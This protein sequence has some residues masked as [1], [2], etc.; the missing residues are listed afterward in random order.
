[1]PQPNL[2]MGCNPNPFAFNAFQGSMN[3]LPDQLD[4]NAAGAFPQDHQFNG[5][6]YAQNGFGYDGQQAHQGQNHFTTNNIQNNNTYYNNN[7]NI[8]NYSV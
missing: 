8:M 2:N 1:M 6:N 5:F 3:M 4:F 7:C